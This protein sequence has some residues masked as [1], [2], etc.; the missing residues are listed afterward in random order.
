MGFYNELMAMVDE[1]T[2]IQCRSGKFSG[3]PVWQDA[4][5]SQALRVTDPRHFEYNPVHAEGLFTTAMDRLQAW[6]KAAL[7]R[8]MANM[9][10][11]NAEDA[12]QALRSTVE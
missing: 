9:G 12:R 7:R 3:E 8:H 11:T 1:I 5:I 4:T 6:H 2:S 10:L